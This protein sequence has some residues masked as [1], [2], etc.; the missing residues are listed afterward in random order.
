MVFHQWNFT[1][2]KVFIYFNFFFHPDQPLKHRHQIWSPF[3]LSLIACHRLRLIAQTVSLYIF[4]LST[5]W[6][7]YI[8]NKTLASKRMA[9]GKLHFLL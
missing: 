3:L 4:F 7:M 6:A 8:G 1:V 9:F 5:I 2:T